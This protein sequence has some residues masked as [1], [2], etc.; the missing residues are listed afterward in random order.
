M[1]GKDTE[2]RAWGE[3][4]YS[5]SAIRE[6]VCR[7]KA[8]GEPLS[9]I[10]RDIRP[11]MEYRTFCRHA[12]RFEAGIDP[13]LERAQNPALPE[14]DSKRDHAAQKVIHSDSVAVDEPDPVSAAIMA[15]AAPGTFERLNRQP[16]YNPRENTIEE[17]F[18]VDE[19]GKSVSGS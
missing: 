15:K 3:A 17:L 7:R 5:F 2:K 12:A 8:L 9:R 6:D 11:P 16:A 13:S 4:R 18:G 1:T 10:Y 14:S 19:V